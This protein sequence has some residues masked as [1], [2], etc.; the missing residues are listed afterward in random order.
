[1]TISSAEDELDQN[2]ICEGCK[3][4]FVEDDVVADDDACNYADAFTA[5]LVYY[6]GKPCHYG[7]LVK[8]IND[9]KVH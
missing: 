3:K 9:G 7:C 1:M 4:E 5:N 8:A 6:E 2:S